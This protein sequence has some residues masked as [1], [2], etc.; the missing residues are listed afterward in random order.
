MQA[1]FDSVMNFLGMVGQFVAQ[2]LQSTILLMVMVQS[3]MLNVYQA[4]AFAPTLVVMSM[5]AVVAMG[6]LKLLVG[7]GG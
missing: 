2:M 6:I 3:T 1:F 7:G 4:M 5:T